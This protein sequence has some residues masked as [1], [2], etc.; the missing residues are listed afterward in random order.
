MLLG[1]AEEPNLGEN[2]PL[3]V[4]CSQLTSPGLS[5]E[6]EIFQQRKSEIFLTYKS[7]LFLDEEAEVD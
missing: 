1:G 6:L 4:A 5:L 7:E 3:S 2:P